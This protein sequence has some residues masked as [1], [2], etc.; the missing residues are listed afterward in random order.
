MLHL[1]VEAVEHIQVLQIPAA[2][3]VVKQ[4]T[5][6]EIQEVPITSITQTGQSSLMLVRIT[7]E[8]AAVVVV[9][10]V[11]RQAQTLR[12]VESV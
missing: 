6:P 4:S 7:Q 8:Q 2:L 10:P 5:E 1:A 9:V 12:M 11:V 3:V